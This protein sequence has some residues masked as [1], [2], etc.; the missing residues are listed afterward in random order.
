[1]TG[2]IYSL[3]IYPILVNPSFNIYRSIA[4]KAFMPA[5]IVGITNVVSFT[6]YN[7]YDD[8]KTGTN[9]KG[10]ILLTK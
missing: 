3:L 4:I 8:P 9:F 5:L 1:M 7:E 10:I 2:E 6:S